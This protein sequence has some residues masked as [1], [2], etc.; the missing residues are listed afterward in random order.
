MHKE[1]RINGSRHIVIIHG[2]GGVGKTQ[3]AIAYAKRHRAEYSAFFWLN[4]KDEDSLRQSFT[5]VARR[6]L[7]EHPSA[8]RL[9]SVD[10]DGNLD[11]VVT[12]MKGWLDLA[13]NTQWLIVYNNYDNPKLP[14]NKD[15]AAFDI[16]RFLPE[17]YH[18]SIVITTRS[19]QVS[20]G[21][22]IHLAKLKNVRDGLQ[23]LSDASRREGVMDGKFSLLYKNT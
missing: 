4:A 23:I 7:R 2:L 20:I 18:G 13:H 6:V 8:S 16:R 11:E 15:Y 14:G 10:M 9:D 19:S 3:L 17:S 1:L 22:R 21:C 5:K 12:A